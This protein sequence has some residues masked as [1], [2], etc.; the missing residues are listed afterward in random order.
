MSTPLYYNEACATCGRPVDIHLSPASEAPTSLHSVWGDLSSCREFK[1]CDPPRPAYGD[2][3]WIHQKEQLPIVRLEVVSLTDRSLYVE[4]VTFRR[5]AQRDG[6]TSSLEAGVLVS[7]LSSD[8]PI[9]RTLIDMDG[10]AVADGDVD[11]YH[12]MGYEAGTYRL[13][14][15]VVLPPESKAV[16]LD[17][18]TPRAKLGRRP[19]SS[20]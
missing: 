9:V 19:L 3:W 15:R 20:G 8:T 14:E 18:E 5:K 12:R 4:A 2:A 17:L 13:Y 16:S 10:K 1:R 11:T 6:D 7:A